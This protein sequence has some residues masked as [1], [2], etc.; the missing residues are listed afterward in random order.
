MRLLGF[1]APPMRHG[2][3]PRGAAQRQKPRPTG[4]IGPDAWADP[5]VTRHRR[6]LETCGHGV[7]RALAKA[8]RCAAPVTGL[9]DATALETI[10]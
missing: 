1:R 10:A 7:I 3:C 5:L 6:D 8:G 4:P 9:V 2:V